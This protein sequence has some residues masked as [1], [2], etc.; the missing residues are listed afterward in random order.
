MQVLVND[1]L[2][3]MMPLAQGVR[4][5]DALSSMLYIPCVEVFACKI[6]A[7]RDIEGFL[8]PG[9]GSLQF[10]LSQYANNTTAF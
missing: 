2:S 5:D 10:T 8:L 4:Q 1:F 3:D 9:A 6:R 7:T